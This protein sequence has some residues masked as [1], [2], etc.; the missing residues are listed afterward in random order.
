MIRNITPQFPPT[1]ERGEAG[2]RVMGGYLDD[3]PSV[4]VA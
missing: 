1:C 2:G 4:L 3:G